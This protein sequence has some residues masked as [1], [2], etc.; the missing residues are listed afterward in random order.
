MTREFYDGITEDHLKQVQDYCKPRLRYNEN[1]PRW[2]LPP[3][4]FREWQ[5]PENVVLVGNCKF[6]AS[7][8]A[9]ATACLMLDAWAK[10][11]IE[12]LHNPVFSD[13]TCLIFRSIRIV[14]Y[15]S[16]SSR[17][18]HAGAIARVGGDEGRWV[19]FADT[20]DRDWS[21]LE[22]ITELQEEIYE[23]ADM[24]DLTWWRKWHSE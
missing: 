1:D 23:W 24:T 11:L 2:R 12:N 4:S 6:Y 20:M 16:S 9:Q 13:P 10:P 18:D 8:A 21:T 14:S 19:R 5:W 7:C 17:A 15:K 22:D 3:R